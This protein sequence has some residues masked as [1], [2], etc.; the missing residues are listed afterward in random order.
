M[1]RLFL[2]PALCAIF[3]CSPIALQAAIYYASP[4]G[5]GDGSSSEQ[6]GSF[7][8]LAPKLKAGDTLYLLE[9]QYDLSVTL[10]LTAKGTVTQ[11]ITICQAPGTAPRTPILDF[12]RQAYGKRGIEIAEGAD[13][14]IISGLTLRYS[15]KNALHN[16]GSHNVFSNL[17]VYGNGDTGVQM[18]AGG[19]NTIENVDSHDNFDYELDKSGNLTLVDFG[20]N[21]DGFADK[22]YT[23]GANTYIGCRAWNNSD[24]GWDFFQRVTSG[25]EPT[26]LI[27]CICYQNG[28]KEY[29]MRTHGRY[30]TDKAFLSQFASPKTV[31]DA[32]GKSI[33][34]SLEH[35]TNLGNGNGFKIGGE[36][37]QNNVQLERCLAVAN[38]VKGFDQNN[39]YGSMT[40]YNCSAYRN[41]IDY[42]FHNNGGGTLIIR[43]CI[44]HQTKSANVFRTMSVSSDHNSWN[45]TNISV[46]DNDFLTLDLEDILSPRQNDGSLPAIAFMH[47]KEG[48]PLI[49]AGADVGIA[50]TGKAPDLGCYEYGSGEVVLPATITLTEGMLSQTLRLGSELTATVI[51][52]GG[53]AEDISVSDLP[54][55]ISSLKDNDKHTIT[56]SG[57]PQA[58]GTYTVTVSTTGPTASKS[59]TLTW[60]VKEAGAG[61]QVVYFT[62]PDDERD[63]L[64]L[65]QLSADQKLDV[66]IA[67]ATKTDPYPEADLIVI[68]PVPASSAA[69]LAALKAVER[70]TLLLKPF[71]LKSSVW[72]WGDSKN[73][74]D[75]RISISDTTH[76]VFS[77]IDLEA[78]NSLSLFSRVTTNGVTCIASWYGSSPRLIASPASAESAAIAEAK[79]GTDMNGT[80][81][82]A[83]FFMIGISEY[84]TTD[85]SEAGL[86]LINN[87]CRYLL[88]LLPS[89]DLT[90]TEDQIGTMA[91]A[92][93]Y[94]VTGIWLGDDESVLPTLPKGIYITGGRKVVR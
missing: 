90:K 78:D 19:D 6:T 84:S 24:D 39:N 68:S 36:Y 45:T 43:N 18:K 38:T 37:T 50:Y 87:A 91:P 46:S 61:F 58:T 77:G 9:G 13:Y 67:D 49:D 12:R 54:Q 31:T 2:L 75:A 53:S 89:T 33:T 42:G 7:S 48:S 66:I 71:M 5:N 57:T 20:G 86:R 92:G 74:S 1:K 64:I 34:V 51:T 70:P 56:L 11:P 40:L 73:T 30:E 28:P 23:G 85:L 76:P 94:S 62:L 3:L 52:W 32:D 47:L 22:Q 69:G 79:A 82:K 44:S 4:S 59:L 80:I 65:Q 72:N 16:S 26:R 27:G 29:D 35:Y 55:G 21:A 17:D 8:T 93:V 14:W 81:L 41:G 83:D 63:R 88:G 25:T 60:I 15:G 10:K